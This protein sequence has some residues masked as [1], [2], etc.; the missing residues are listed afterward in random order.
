MIRKT[1]AV[2]RKGENKKEEKGKTK[3]SEKGGKKT[4]KTG[5]GIECKKKVKKL[6]LTIWF[7]GWMILRVW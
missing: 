6:K 1:K 5:R 3:G 7:L 4:L 2:E